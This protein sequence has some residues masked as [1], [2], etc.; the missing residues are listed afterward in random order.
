MARI[1]SSGRVCIFL[2]VAC[3]ASSLGACRGVLGIE[4]LELVDAGDGGEMRADTSVGPESGTAESGGQDAAQDDVTSPDSA[5]SVDSSPPPSDGAG[6]DASPYAMCV[7]EGQMCRPCCRT[8]YLSA[9][10]VFTQ[11][12][13]T[14]GCLCGAS[15]QCQSE[16]VASI[17]ASPPN[18]STPVMAC[19]SCFDMAVISPTAS[20]CMSADQTC[21]GEPSCQDVIDC[22]NSCP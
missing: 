2:F 11:L 15:G 7:A 1:P 19:N 4:N 21:E 12:A 13:G 9:N 14:D 20:A 10:T 16:C 18:G 6:P 17:C 8:T 22:L 3:A 5:P